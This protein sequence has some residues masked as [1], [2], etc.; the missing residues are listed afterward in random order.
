MTFKSFDNDYCLEFDFYKT[1]SGCNY[2]IKVIDK[3]TNKEVKRVNIDYTEPEFIKVFDSNNFE[4]KKILARIK[5]GLS[6]GILLLSEVD[7]SN[8]NFEDLFCS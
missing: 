4:D 8:E 2:F 6:K 5:T 7:Y 3:K 1:I